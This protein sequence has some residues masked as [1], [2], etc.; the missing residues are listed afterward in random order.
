MQVKIRITLF[1]FVFKKILLKTW[2][3]KKDYIKIVPKNYKNHPKNYKNHPTFFSSKKYKNHPKKTK[4]TL[5]NSKMPQRFF[6]LKNTKILL[7]NTNMPL[8]KYKITTK[9]IFRGIFVFFRG[10]FN[11]I[12]KKKDHNFKPNAKD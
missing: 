12:L 2:I 10:D 11:M 5:K 3:K 6:P 9:N 7:K 8:K 1:V 4:I